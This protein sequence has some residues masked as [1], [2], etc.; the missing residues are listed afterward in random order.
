MK[1]GGL[2]D[3]RE[4]ANQESHRC[5]LR[6][7]LDY[8]QVLDE[9][10]E[11]SLAALSRDLF[12]RGCATSSGRPYTP[13]MVRRMRARL[14]EA[15]LKGATLEET[16]PKKA[17][18]NKS[19]LEEARPKGDKKATRKSRSNAKSLSW[20]PHDA[21]REAITTRNSY[22]LPWLLKMARKELGGQLA[23]DLMRGWLD[24]EH[25]SWIRGALQE[26]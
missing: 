10:R 13:E 18:P 24:T 9:G 23:D 5:A 12:A 21:I 25:A 19:R 15:R 22:A 4:K 26:P 2:R 16:S 7:S 3:P 1:L 6:R 11:K 8:E 14:E 20:D 17:T